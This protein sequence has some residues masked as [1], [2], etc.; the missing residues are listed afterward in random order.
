ME[1]RVTTLKKKLGGRPALGRRKGLL[2]IIRQQVQRWRP[3]PNQIRRSQ[4]PDD[5]DHAAGGLIRAQGGG[6]AGWDPVGVAWKEREPIGCGAAHDDA[7]D[8]ILE[9]P[10]TEGNN[11]GGSLGGIGL[12]GVDFDELSAVGF[13]GAVAVEAE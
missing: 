12:V 2:F 4:F 9:L 5:L 13:G 1:S 6:G 10:N 8:G 11:L 3:T 7:V